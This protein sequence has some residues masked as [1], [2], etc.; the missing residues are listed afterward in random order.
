MVEDG[1]PLNGDGGWR[2]DADWEV[3]CASTLSSFGDSPV[4]SVCG[5]GGPSSPVIFGSSIAIGKIPVRLPVPLRPAHQVPPWPG[6]SSAFPELINGGSEIGQKSTP[7]ATYYGSTSKGLGFYHV[8]VSE[9]EET[10]WL[11]FNNCGIVSV[12]KGSISLSKL[13]KDLCNIFCK[14]KKWPWQLRELEPN[15]FLVRFPPWK[16]VKELSEERQHFLSEFPAFVLEKDGVNVKIFVWTGEVNALAELQDC[17]VS[18]RG[19]PPKWCAWKVFGQLASI[20]R[21][22]MDVDWSVMFKSFYAEVKL[23]ISCRDPSKI[24]K[25]RIVEMN[26]KLYLLLLNVEGVPQVG[27]GGFAPDDDLDGDNGVPDENNMDTDPNHRDASSSHSQSRN[28]PSNHSGALLSPQRSLLDK[29][30][31]SHLDDSVW[32][33]E[34]LVSDDVPVIDVNGVENY[35]FMQLGEKLVNVEYCSKLLVDMDDIGESDDDLMG[36]EHVDVKSGHAS[37][38]EQLEVFGPEICE[39]LSAVK[40]TLLPFLNDAAGNVSSENPC[41]APNQRKLSGVLW[42]LQGGV[43]G[44][45][46]L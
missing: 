11:N 39:K 10:K 45:M 28:T 24:P 2:L 1:S 38:D 41:P 21:I 26:Q 14:T 13:E 32:D 43:Q 31:Y 30:D 35:V 46:V 42:L 15:S 18:I 22:L 5:S 6:D 12:R 23:L 9:V 8:D 20:S 7:S 17:R 27:D 34:G 19:I 4:R 3:S 25:E 16:D 36:D 40:R 44:I 37:D 29:L 33:W